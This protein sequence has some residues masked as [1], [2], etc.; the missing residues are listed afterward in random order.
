MWSWKT[1]VDAVRPTGVLCQLS[2]SGWEIEE[3]LKKVPT[4]K[5]YTDELRNQQEKPVFQNSFSQNTKTDTKVPVVF[6][7][8]C[9]IAEM[10]LASFL[11]QQMIES[12]HLGFYLW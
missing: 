2:T 9:K 1:S 5:K 11:E 7:F 10:R 3:T 12:Q 8:F 4:P 6:S